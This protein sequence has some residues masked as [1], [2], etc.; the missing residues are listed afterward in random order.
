MLTRGGAGRIGGADPDRV[1]GSTPLPALGSGGAERGILTPGI[2]DGMPT[3][4][5]I[6]GVTGA[7][8]IAANAPHAAPP[9]IRY[10]ANPHEPESPQRVK[11]VFFRDA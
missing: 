3:G 6:R 11:C 9:D 4:A 2:R 5:Q 8:G 10:G 7:T 1:S